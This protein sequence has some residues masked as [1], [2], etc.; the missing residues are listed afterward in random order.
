MIDGFQ[1]L[2]HRNPT[3]IVLRDY[4]RHNFSNTDENND[5][6]LIYDPESGSETD[7]DTDDEDYDP[8]PMT[9]SGPGHTGVTADDIHALI[10]NIGFQNYESTNNVKNEGDERVHDES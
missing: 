1:I 10:W 7:D 4:N 8:P 2:A 3:G 6:Y 9:A 5:K